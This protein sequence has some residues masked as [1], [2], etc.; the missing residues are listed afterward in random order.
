ML[1]LSRYL[2]KHRSLIIK[3]IN[4]DSISTAVYLF[5]GPAKEQ[6]LKTS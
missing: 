2:C 4:P 3:H 6:L 5:F 1:K